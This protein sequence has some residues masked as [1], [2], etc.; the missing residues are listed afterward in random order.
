MTT[1]DTTTI[2]KLTTTTTDSSRKDID[3]HDDDSNNENDDNSQLELQEVLTTSTPRNLRSLKGFF[4]VDARQSKMITCAGAFARTY[5][6]INVIKW[7]H[8][9]AT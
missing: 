6:T 3:N 7:M 1:T 4:Q 5:H 2:T 9:S 8:D